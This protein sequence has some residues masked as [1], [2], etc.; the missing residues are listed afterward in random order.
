MTEASFTYIER[1]LNLKLPKEY[2]QLM[3][4][5]EVQAFGFMY[6]GLFTSSVMVVDVTLGLRGVAK[7]DGIALPN[8]LIVVSTVNGGDDVLLDT[9]S[10]DLEM[11]LWNHETH[12]LEPFGTLK[13]F[14]E[15]CRRF[16]EINC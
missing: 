13:D 8:G 2:R 7:D 12:G 5:E 14:V 3:G 4:S 6:C 16:P 15:A 1:E 11:K 9:D 10:A